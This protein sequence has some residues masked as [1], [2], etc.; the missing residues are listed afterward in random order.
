MAIVVNAILGH[1]ECKGAAVARDME[2]VCWAMRPFPHPTLR[3]IPGW[4]CLPW[5]I[6]GYLR[7][8]GLRARC[9]CWGTVERL[10]QNVRS[11]RSTIVI[12]GEPLRHEGPHYKGWAH[13]KVLYGLGSLP[14]PGHCPSAARRAGLYFVD[15]GCRREVDGQLPA[16]L[17]WQEEAQFLRQ[18]TNLMRLYVEIDPGT[19]QGES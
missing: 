4:A 2:K 16:G 13:A 15:P 6:A 14:D 5:G 11:G 3:K 1:E 17:S 7:D 9:R 8:L 18:W 10:R 19:N 12:V